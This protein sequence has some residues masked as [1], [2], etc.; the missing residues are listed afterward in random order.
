MD[1]E[2]DAFILAL[3]PGNCPEGNVS[4]VASSLD[5]FPP[6]GTPFVRK[7]PGTTGGLRRVVLAIIKSGLRPAALSAAVLFLTALAVAAQVPTTAEDF[8]APGTQPL[9]LN[10]PM[11]TPDQCTICHSGFGEPDLEPFNTW[12][13]GMMA[14]AGRDPLMWAA[15]AIANQDASNAG[16]ACLRCHLPQG[17]LAG[18]SAD[19]DGTMMLADTPEGAAA[20]QGVQ[21]SVCHRLVDPFAA[22]ENPVEDGPIL[23]ALADPVTTLANGVMV[24]DPDNRLRGPFDIIADLGGD[25]HIP[26][27]TT[28]ISPYHQSS[29][30]CGTCHNVRIPTFTKNPITGEFELNALDTPSPDISQGFPE[31]LTYDEWAASEYAATGVFA[32]QFGFNKDVVSSCQ[33]CHMPD[34]T[35]KDA[36]AGIVRDDMPVHSMVGANTFIPEVLPFDPRFGNEVDPALLDAG[37]VRA[38][39]MLRK[40]ATLET[41][42]S[43]G[44]LTVRVT[45]ETGHKL[46]TGY[47]EGRRMWLFVNA[48]DNANN[49]VFES[50][51]YT[52]STAELAG[53]DKAPADPEHDP[54]LRVWETH[55]GISDD[56]ATQLGVPPGISSNLALNNKIYFDNRIPPRGFTN[57]AF[58]AFDGQPVGVT[59]A[60][61]QYWDEAVY[62]VGNTAVRAEVV[63]YYQTTSKKYVEFLR[64][65]NTTNS[66]GLILFDLWDQN[67]KA[68]PVEMARAFVETNVKTIHRCQKVVS[69]LQQHYLKIYAKEWA[70]CYEAEAN[71]FSCDTARRDAKIAAADTK[72]R[73]KLG[74]IEDGRCSGN[75][76]TPITLGHGTVC[77]VPCATTKL[78]D[79]EG[80]ASC[81]VCMAEAVN[82]AALAGAFGA[83]PPALPSSVPAATRSCQK[84]LSQ[85]ATDLSINWA[86]ALARCEQRNTTGKAV[87]PAD[88]SMDSKIASVKAKAAKRVDKCED[89]TGLAGCGV[90]GDPTATKACLEAA[91]ENLVSQVVKVPFP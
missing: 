36:V 5:G 29:E 3:E 25:P 81:A 24:A 27:R 75:N 26:I 49:V 45:N 91:V 74:G 87:P 79:I 20:R 7:L 19:P 15:L 14:Q 61:G 21:C 77:P 30:I 50:G 44:N 58:E 76:L 22:P 53:Y 65:E 60:D 56:L 12:Q 57:A 47:P 33:D 4:S 18:L 66:S 43:G 39:D 86:K 46:P 41:D 67:G 69:R 9:S 11:E 59:Y 13:G 84:L 70:R 89:F 83:E 16:E 51:R 1:F 8:K 10:D 85:A 52:F 71:G 88:C 35:A 23:A 90:G 2:N 82:D 72:L 68:A 32:P 17:W 48:F 80:L 78:F 40:A 38:T 63:L 62:P 37:I 64:D 34:V 28:L 54:Y 73:D 6:C 31:Q 42:I 55:H